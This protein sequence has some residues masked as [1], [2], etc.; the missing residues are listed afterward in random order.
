MIRLRVARSFAGSASGWLS[1]T[2][3]MRPLLA[4]TLGLLVNATLEAQTIARENEVKAALLFNFCHFVQ[5][6]ETA[7]RGDS[8]PFI[9]AILGRDPFGRFIDELVRDERAH[10]RTIE[11][12]RY[13]RVE[14]ITHAHL[15]YVGRSEQ[16][17]IRSVIAALRGRPILS[18]GEEGE[19]GYTRLG[20]VVGFFTERNNVRIR[21]NLDEARRAGL[22]ISSKLLRLADVLP[23][24]N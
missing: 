3:R 9:I 20:G 4:A 24:Q 22:T 10:G 8:A 15:L 14:D 7:F 17:R 19:P 23:V 11:V 6:P 2:I 18:V 16:A 12:R 21:I 1:D 5:W 13:A